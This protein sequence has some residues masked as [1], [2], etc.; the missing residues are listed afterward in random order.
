MGYKVEH[1]CPQCGAPVEL[2]ETDHIVECAY[3]RVKSYLAP[4]DCFR[5]AL[6]RKSAHERLIFA[7]Y[8]RFKGAVFSCTGLSISQR[9]A[10]ITRAGSPLAA[11]P[12]S[13]GL[14]PQTLKMR[15]L[16]ARPEDLFIPFTLKPSELLARVEKTPGVAGGPRALFHAFI[17]DV[18]SVIYLPLFLMGGRLYDAVL[19]RPMCAAPW[20]E[21]ML[22]DSCRAQPSWRMKTLA[23]VCPRCG[24]SLDGERDSVVLFCPNCD[25]AWAASMGKFVTVDFGVSPHRDGDAVYLPFWKIAAG[26]KDLGIQSFDDFL[27]VGNQPRV[28]A[29]GASQGE[30]SFWSPAFKIRPKLFLSLA[31]QLT[32]A[33]PEPEC[34]R[35]LPKGRRHPVT[36]PRGEAEKSIKLTL[37]RSALNKEQLFPLLPEARFETGGSLL[38][39]LPFKETVHDFIHDPTNASINKNALA[40]GRY[41]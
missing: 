36:L 33:Q 11:I 30:M 13:L 37:A 2:D 12:V 31:C 28:D 25:S 15:F 3:C 10:D 16:E 8:L 9:L 26:C 38:V 5:F 7:P 24:W 21:E 29:E 18:I 14:R 23:T 20:A 39:Y 17:G 27:R 40:F 32:L 1:E 22:A 34:R 41:L 6:P 4:S 19:D 35:E